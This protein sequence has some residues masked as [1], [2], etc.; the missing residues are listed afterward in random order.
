VLHQDI[1]P[2]NILVKSN[3]IYLT[4]FGLSKNF[5]GGASRS[6][7]AFVGTEEY[8]APECVLSGSHGYAADVFSLGCVF[9]EM[10]TVIR[11]KKLEY[12]RKLRT[13][14][15]PTSFAEV[16]AE[17]PLKYS[18]QSNLTKVTSWLDS[19]RDDKDRT[20]DLLVSVIQSML[21]FEKELRATA[22]AAS[23]ELENYQAFYCCCSH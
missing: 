18:Y 17:R 8:Q 12:F 15:L 21:V 2:Q 10:L 23:R 13:E 14:P 6:Y 22:S 4:D 5:R 19:L 16:Y 20:I 7:A 1:K 11:K 9:S 3:S